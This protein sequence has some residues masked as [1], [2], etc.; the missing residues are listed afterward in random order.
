[1][2]TEPNDQP[3]PV[4][5][6]PVKLKKH[7]KKSDRSGRDDNEPGSSQEIEI[8]TRSL[9]LSELRDMRKDFSCHP[10]EHIV[11]WLLRCWDNGASNLELEGKEAKQL[12]S[13]AREGGIDKAIENKEQV[14]S[15]W[16]RLVSGVR[17]RY[18]FSDDFV[19]YP[20]KW[21]NMEKGIQY[22]RELAVR[23][24]VFYDTDDEQVPTDPDEVQCTA[25]MWRKFVRSAP[26][27][28]A[29]SLAVVNWK[30]KEA[31]TVDEVAVRLWQYEESL[32]SSLVSAV[33]KLAWEFQQIKENMSYSPPVWAS[34]SDIRGKCSSAQ[35]KEYRGY[36]PRD[37]LSFTCVTTERT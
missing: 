28:Y 16:R 19:C 32:S 5:V 17:E 11:T 3:V 30:G 34:I 26:S 22:L 8:I 37:T 35:E 4:V 2:A 7:A 9:S 20:G 18:I 15:L 33:K 25:S 21:T 13:L 23:E 12:G 14:L 6:A 24:L 29:S 31:P 1:M 27:S 10:G 36:R